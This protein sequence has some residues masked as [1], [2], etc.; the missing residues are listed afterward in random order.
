MGIV[1]SYDNELIYYCFITNG[2][3]QLALFV[4]SDLYINYYCIVILIL[5]IFNPTM[6]EKLNLDELKS[7]KTPQC[8][9]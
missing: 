5:D 8:S 6:L 3:K 7:L 1:E 2:N 9:D 4:K